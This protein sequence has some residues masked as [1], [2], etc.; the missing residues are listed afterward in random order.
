MAKKLQV[1]QVRSSIGTLPKQRA[2]LRALG[3]RKMSAER[4]HD[5]TPV[6]RGMID[7]VSHLVAVK[8]IEK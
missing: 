7:K 4:I 2:T 5:D 1:K 8:E 3:L 6:I